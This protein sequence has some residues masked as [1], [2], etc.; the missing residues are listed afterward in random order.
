MLRSRSVCNYGRYSGI[1]NSKRDVIWL[2]AVA[3]TLPCYPGC[4]QQ[5]EC[6]L[7]SQLDYPDDS[8]HHLEHST[9]SECKTTVG[10][11]QMTALVP[12]NQPFLGLFSTGHTR[13]YK[14]LFRTV[15]TRPFDITRLKRQS[16]QLSHSWFNSWREDRAGREKTVHTIFQ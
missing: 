14:A 11:L 16:S 12:R 2:V 15:C 4:L 13:H 10:G 1:W 5:K 9:D 6:Q 7:S 3:L 8:S